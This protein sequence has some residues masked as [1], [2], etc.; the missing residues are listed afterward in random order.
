MG[1]KLMQNPWKMIFGR[2]GC[3]LDVQVGGG[4]SKSERPGCFLWAFWR[5]LADLEC[6]FGP[7]WPET[8]SEI[9]PFGIQSWTNEKN[10]VPKRCQK[11][12]WIFDCN[13]MRKVTFQKGKVIEKPLFFYCFFMICDFREKV[14]KIK[15]KGYQDGSQN[16]WKIEPWLIFEILGCLLG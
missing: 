12:T 5:H 10:E 8:G 11:K 1:V 16:G 4:P 2:L 13:L 9:T 6:L 14:W 15:Q 3:R 7:S